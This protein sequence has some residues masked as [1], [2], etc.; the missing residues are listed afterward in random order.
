MGLVLLLARLLPAS[1]FGIAGLAKLTDRP[2]ARKAL[3]GFAVSERLAGA[4]AIALPLAELAVG[5]ALLLATTA[6][7]AGVA[8]FM[9]LALFTTGIAI[10]MARGRTP[11][12]HCFRQLHSEA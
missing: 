12:C 7:W 3:I 2:G 11:E 8:A 9:L 10:A 1:V 6:A 4:G 5:A